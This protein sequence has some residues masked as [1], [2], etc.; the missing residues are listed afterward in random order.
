MDVRAMLHNYGDYELNA[1][2]MLKIIFKIRNQLVKSRFA[3]R[4]HFRPANK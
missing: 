3:R 2:E 1:S 4:F